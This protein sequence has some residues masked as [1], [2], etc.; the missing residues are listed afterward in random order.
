MSL[1]KYQ[2]SIYGDREKRVRRDDW[3][4]DIN[5]FSPA[6][7]KKQENAHICGYTDLKPMK[8]KKKKTPSGVL[9]WGSTN[10]SYVYSERPPFSMNKGYILADGTN[11]YVVIT[12]RRYACLPIIF[13]LMI[14][15]L[16]LLPYCNKDTGST[17][18]TTPW[19]PVIEANLGEDE[20]SNTQSANSQIQIAGFSSWHISAGE[21][22]NLPITLENPEGNPCYFSFSIVLENGE[23]IYQSNMVPPGEA[24][25]KITINRSLNAGVYPAIVH[26]DTN[27]LK[28]G[29][30]MNKADLNINICVS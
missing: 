21:S 11:D 6:A 18:T 10:V 25:K 22:E 4:I 1:K 27:S 23:K 26:I 3:P 17:P 28:D 20:T 24:I 30:E 15:L 8:P 14:L 16:L 2:T 5:Y 7:F 19:N 29:K 12:T 9:A 13:V